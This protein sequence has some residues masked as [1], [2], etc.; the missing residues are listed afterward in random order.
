MA[1]KEERS[2]MSLAASKAWET[3]RKNFVKQSGKKEKKKD[4]ER[5]RLGKAWRKARLKGEKK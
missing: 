2:K 4:G 3:R 1:K 5:K